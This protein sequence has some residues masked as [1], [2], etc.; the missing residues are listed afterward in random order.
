MFA[1]ACPAHPVAGC[2]IDV[3]VF[4]RVD[5]TRWACS[6]ADVALRAVPYGI[7]LVIGWRSVAEVVDAVVG[8]ASISVPN[9]RALWTRT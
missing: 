8:L 7:L 3:G 5:V 9:M 2:W 6:L 1:L 4:W